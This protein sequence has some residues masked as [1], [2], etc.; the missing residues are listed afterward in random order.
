MFE[1]VFNKVRYE[2]ATCTEDAVISRKKA[3]IPTN[4][5]HSDEIEYATFNTRTRM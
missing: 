4:M 2:P 1:E 3:P 5:R